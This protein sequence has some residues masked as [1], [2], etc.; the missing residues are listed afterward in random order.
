MSEAEQTVTDQVFERAGNDPQRH[1][2]LSDSYCADRFAESNRHSCCYV[3][4]K[5]WFIFDGKRWIKDKVLAGRL[6]Q[7]T[8]LEIA[9]DPDGPR[10]T[11]ADAKKLASAAA[12]S[13]VL[14]K[15]MQ[16]PDIYQTD[17]FGKIF[18]HKPH[19]LN[20]PEGTLDLPRNGVR[21]KYEARKHSAADMLTKIARVSPNADCPTPKWRAFLESSLLQ[22]D[23]DGEVDERTTKELINYVRRSIAYGIT[24]SCRLQL[25]FLFWGAG[26]DGKGLLFRVLSYILGEYLGTTSAQLFQR[27]KHGEGHP[28]SLARLEGFRLIVAHEPS[29]ELPWDDALLKRISGGDAIAARHMREDEYEIELEGVV[30][31]TTNVMPKLTELSRAMKRR[32]RI[33]PWTSIPDNQVDPHLYDAL[34]KEA[35]GI[36]HDLL[37]AVG[38][39]ERDGLKSP[40]AVEQATTNYMNDQDVMADFIQCCFEIVEGQW[41]PIKQVHQLYF[42]WRQATAP[43]RN[44]TEFG[45]NTLIQKWEKREGIRYSRKCGEKRNVAGFINAKVRDNWR[46]NI[47]L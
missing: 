44:H 26:G 9:N 35:P 4:D 6:M 29:P 20:T 7:V 8:L 23:D 15:A 25:L 46:D 24:G 19:V 30:Y 10:M 34:I 11:P 22:V 18:D 12:Q 36:L 1:P 5:D 13:A 16:H 14:K 27:K 45:R 33:V 42:D 2:A 39:L 17:T 21:K 38:E 28:T 40:K 31:I 32:L 3:K 43:Y 37:L 41:V 47:E